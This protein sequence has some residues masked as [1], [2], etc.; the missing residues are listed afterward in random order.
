MKKSCWFLA[1]LICESYFLA[2]QTTTFEKTYGG[3]GDE[4]IYNFS[5]TADKGYVLTGSTTSGTSGDQDV[6][7]V[8]TDSLGNMQWAKQFGDAGMDYGSQVLA[9]SNGYAIFGLSQT[10]PILG[11]AGNDNLVVRTDVTGKVL[12]K[13]TFGGSD[14]DNLH[15][16]LIT[17]DGGFI[18][19]GNT[20]T[21][22]AGHDDIS[23]L[24]MDSVGNIQWYKTYGTINNNDQGCQIIGDS[25]G[26][27]IVAGLTHVGPDDHDVLVM[28]IDSAGNLLWAKRYPYSYNENAQGIIKARNGDYLIIGD[29][30]PG[31]STTSNVLLLR[32]DPNGN[33]KWVKLYSSSDFQRPYLWG[34]ALVELSDGSMVMEGVVGTS[35]STNVS[36]CLI[37]TDSLGNMLWSKTYGGANTS[38]GT[39]IYQTEDQGLI[40]AGATTVKSNGGFD[41]LLLKT[42]ATGDSYSTGSMLLSSS[43]LTM[44]SVD[45]GF[46]VSAHSISVQWGQFLHDA[47]TFISLDTTQVI[48]FSPRA[49]ANN[50]LRTTPI[51]I[52]FNK[53]VNA[54]LFSDSS[55]IVYGSISG[56]HS[57]T[58]QYNASSFTVTISPK[59]NFKAG[60]IVQVTLTGA[61]RDSLHRSYSWMFTAKSDSSTGI[62]KSVSSATVGDNPFMIIPIDINNDGYTDFASV[63]NTSATVT[64]LKNNKDGTF[65]QVQTISVG[66]CPSA[67]AAIDADGDGH[68]DLAVASGCQNS[69]VILKNDGTGSFTKSTTITTG[70]N[71]PWDII[72]ADVDG[73]GKDELIVA[74]GG[75]SNIAI[76]SNYNNG[77]FVL[78]TLY[79]VGNWPVNITAAD[80]NNDGYIDLI[81]ANHRG[82]SVSVLLNNG[83][84]LFTTDTTINVGTEPWSVVAAN[85]FGNG[86]MDLAVANGASNT[87]SIIKNLGYGHF[88]LNNTITVAALPVRIAASDINGDGNV[89]LIVGSNMSNSMSLYKNDGYG[90]FS[91]NPVVTSLSGAP[92]DII[93][94]DIDNDGIM[95]LAALNNGVDQVLFLKNNQQNIIPPDT[96]NKPL[97]IWDVPNDNGKHVFVRWKTQQSPY[98]LGVSYFD[99][100]R[101]DQTA[102]TFVQGKIPIDSGT[103]YQVVA[104]TIYDSTISNGMYWSVFR[105]LARKADSSYTI[106]G[107]DSGYSV[108]NLPPPAPQYG[109]VTYTL[110][111]A[112]TIR[113]FAVPN[114][115]NDLK[116]YNVYASTTPSYIPSTLTKIAFVT[117]TQ[118]VDYYKQGDAYY[119]KITAVDYSGN[120]SPA[121]SIQGP[122]GVVTD[123]PLIYHLEQNFPNPFNPST[124]ISFSLMKEGFTTLSVYNVLGQKVA[125][126]VE[127]VLQ[128]GDQNA[129]FDASRL[130]SGIYFYKLQSGSFTQIRKMLLMK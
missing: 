94:F 119:Y 7:L 118:Y 42:N 43:S 87:V 63:D 57:S 52:A 92:R 49:N 10:N 44:I 99:L 103:I 122:C 1:L 102:W 64:I 21:F 106:I 78:D 19:Q 15:H 33:V 90:N 120:E 67:I 117:D 59:T 9:L 85:F 91:A 98:A 8:K 35:S 48:S 115:Y 105:V 82:N 74:N 68:M 53:N 46:T 31:G 50:V 13:T 27:V 24:K 58:F 11:T 5:R 32:I 69:V 60:D 79:N 39:D 124:K 38:F 128:A 88:N 12:W 100:Y 65:S 61:L 37:K 20:A 129:T 81:V 114:I 95:D 101:W 34:N 86:L 51:T 45:A 3:S 4:Y 126:L 116:G 109:Y 121:L 84:G 113:W 96:S 97:C 6:C 18:A 71:T 73:D 83:K 28:K 55:V 22:D 108:D 93:P 36:G 104:P 29:S 123:K 23:L 112:R 80:I 75:S 47:Y 127:Q 89:D 14:N 40:I 54:S 26:N 110:A 2:A 125:T 107:P 62:F 16:A 72:A 130:P 66:S 41:C 77:T 111:N 30:N 76:Y 25:C 17:K 70:L 56:V